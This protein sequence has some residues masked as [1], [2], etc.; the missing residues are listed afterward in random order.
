[1]SSGN[2]QMEEWKRW[3]YMGKALSRKFRA[4]AL[5]LLERYPD[6]F[7]PNFDHNKE[8][9]KKLNIFPS[10]KVR[11]QVAGYITRRLKRSGLSR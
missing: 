3:G 6:L 8:A 9:L 7:A 10:K 1:M 4:V 5:E 2:I 11:N